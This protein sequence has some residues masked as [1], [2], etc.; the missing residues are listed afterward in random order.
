MALVDESVSTVKADTHAG[1]LS[2]LQNFLE[3]SASLDSTIDSALSL[4]QSRPEDTDS[5]HDLRLAI[6]RLTENMTDHLGTATST[7]MGM[8]DRKELAILSEM[9]DIPIG[10]NNSRARADTDISEGDSQ[11]SIASIKRL[12]W[13]SSK[14]LIPLSLPMG[15]SASS[16][17][18]LKADR[19]HTVHMSLGGLPLED[20]FTTLPKRKPRASKRSS[21]AHEWTAHIA[22]DLEGGDKEIG[23]PIE[24]QT[25][26]SDESKDAEADLP[27]TP[28]PRRSLATP[29]RSSPLSR[30]DSQSSSNNMPHRHIFP[31]VP[32]TPAKHPL[33]PSPLPHSPIRLDQ[34]RRSLQS[35]PYFHSDRSDLTSPGRASISGS[36]DMAR[37]GSLQVSDLQMLRDQSTNGSSPHR[38]LDYPNGALL[39]PVKQALERP[40]IMRAPSLSPLTLPGLKAACLGVHMKRR[41]MACC[42]L[43]LRFDPDTEYWEEV[44]RSLGELVAGMTAEIGSLDTAQRLAKSELLTRPNTVAQPPWQMTSNRSPTSYPDFAP[45]TSDHAHL[46]QQIE[47]MQ[48]SLHRTWTEL[49]VIRSKLGGSEPHGLNTSWSA[50]RG[51]LGEL[52]RQWERGKDSVSRLEALGHHSNQIDET[53]DGNA[54][55]NDEAQP[56][57]AFLKAWDDDVEPSSNATDSVRSTSDDT[58]DTFSSHAHDQGHQHD[59]QPIDRL[60]AEVLPPPG[61]DIVFEST[62]LPAGMGRSKLTREERIKAMKEARENGL[63]SSAAQESSREAM[64]LGGD[65]VGELKSMI[66][67]IRKR[68]GIE[69]VEPAPRAIEATQHHLLDPTDRRSE[70]PAGFADDLKRAFVFPSQARSVGSQESR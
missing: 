58:H 10:P 63:S 4:L 47:I 67:L 28:N 46:R 39:S 61:Q 37:A 21:W 8:V 24:L 1:N 22:Q 38:S 36:S 44:R 6:H 56:L 15:S 12:S 62:P 66:G 23:G 42:L 40:V 51:E 65:V 70:L 9:Y 59:T 53:T 33:L 54:D 27:R 43:G 19:G 60:M 3:T 16:P 2:S 13:N 57:P 64:D 20:R 48:T 68:K 45:R 69:E 32:P 29:R 25:S 50:V 26:S 11:Q 18:R 55:G 31:I 30:R 49:E 35:M 34:K 41:K 5:L 7:L 52:I 17:A 14:P